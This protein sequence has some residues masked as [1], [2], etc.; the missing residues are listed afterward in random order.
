[1]LPPVGMAR[2]LDAEA[3]MNCPAEG[4]KCRHRNRRLVHAHGAALI[5][6]EL[7]CDRGQDIER[8]LGDDELLPGIE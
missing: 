5:K 4:S 8:K 2:H 1:M 3:V 7:V 6:N